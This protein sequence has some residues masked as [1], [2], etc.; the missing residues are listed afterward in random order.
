MD[1]IEA[2]VIFAPG[3]SPSLKFVLAK[4]TALL[5]IFAVVTDVAA[6]LSVVTFKFVIAAVST[7]LSASSLEP[8][9]FAAICVAVIVSFANFAPVIVASVIFT[10][11][12]ALSARVAVTI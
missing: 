1:V 9:A 2:E 4:V 12:T 10:L 3:I 7:A 11:V 5:A 8:I 6:N